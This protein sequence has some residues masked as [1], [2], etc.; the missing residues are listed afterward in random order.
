MES[1]AENR[2]PRPLCRGKGEKEV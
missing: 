1:A 2:P